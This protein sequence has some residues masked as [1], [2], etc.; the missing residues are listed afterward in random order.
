MQ[1]ADEFQAAIAALWAD[2]RP[3]VLARVE[4]L[5][6]ES[7]R[8]RAAVH[9]HTLAGTL[10]SFGFTEASAAAR[11]AERAVAAGDRAALTAAVAR[12]RAVMDEPRQLHH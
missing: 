1:Q 5:A 6:T 10:G 7:D 4:A 8:E 9:A 3:R 12:L 11:E 2:A